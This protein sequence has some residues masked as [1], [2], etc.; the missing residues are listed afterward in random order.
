[1]SKVA[2]RDYSGKKVFVGVDVHKIKYSV[3]VVCDGEVVK[4]WSCPAGPESLAEQ[5]LRYFQG[6]EIQAAYEAG[7]SGF[8]LHRTLSATGKINSLVVNAGSIPVGN[9]R[10][11]TDAR[12]ARKIAEELAAGK[13]H[14]IYIPTEA[15]EDARSLSRGR[16]QT[17]DRRK[18][19]ANQFKG[20]IHHMGFALPADGKV[21]EA[22]IESVEKAILPKLTEGHLFAL[23]ELIQGWREE[24]ER[25]KRFDRALK[26]QAADDELEPIYRSAPGIGAVSARMLSNE[27]AD[28]TRFDNERQLFSALGLTPSED[29]SGERVRKGNIT[30]QG[31][32]RLRGILTEVAWRAIAKDQS[33]KEFYSRVAARRDSKRAIVAVSRKILGRLR[34]CLR[35]RIHWQDLAHEPESASGT[36]SL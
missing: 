20:K 15:E 7:F 27:L 2:S 4:K 16:A 31:N 11:K 26:L 19:L 23:K 22:F 29:S 18:R 30:R 17:V 25:I 33:L 35:N 8:G 5:L 32:S 9:S 14:S 36:C 1:M 3:S 12:D 10:V 28:M 24:T 13:L 21:S 34:H 6:A